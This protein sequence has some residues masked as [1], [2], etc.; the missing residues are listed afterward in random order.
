MRILICGG[1]VAG[2]TL[3]ALL[4]QRGVKPLVVETAG[5]YG[6]AG[7]LLGLWSLGNRVLY[8][9]GLFEKFKE[10]S[11]PLNRY[12]L[13][14]SR[15]KTL[16]S[17]ELKTLAKKYGEIR[18]LSRAEVLDIL[19]NFG[20]GIEVR[21]NCTIESLE[22]KRG[23][24]QVRLSDGSEQEC[25]LVVGA[26]G[27]NSRVRQL[28]FGKL[29]LNRTG[30]DLYSG[31]LAPEK[32][33]RDAA[34]EF[35]AAKRFL[36]VYSSRC[37]SQYALVVPSK[38]RS[39]AAQDARRATVRHHLDKFGGD[40]AE[41]VRKNLDESGKVE[42]FELADIKIS[43]WSAG[44][45]LLIGDAAAAFLPTAGIGASMAMESAAVLNDE[46][47]RVNA[48]Y[49]PRA[50]EFFVKRRRKRIDLIQK[51][52]RQLL[53]IAALKSSLLTGVRNFIIPYL[54]EKRLFSSIAKSMDEPI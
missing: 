54:S 15:G 44:R 46:L 50:I 40:F 45:A 30:W 5:E 32:L 36:G 51:Q 29:P 1:G 47:S 16:N 37:R 34:T 18:T 26:D 25:D 10:I 41:T 14:N 48:E 17:Y 23:A 38:E 52:S 49:V 20:G 2:L 12:T 7:Y 11:A 22:Q 13:H 27:I 31:W 28:L 21:M 8:G 39:N 9:L 19:R 3:A 6:D 24:A 35:W 33:P 43:Q 4:D 42:V 53:R